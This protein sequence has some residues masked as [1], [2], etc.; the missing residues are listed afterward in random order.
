[1]GIVKPDKGSQGRG[2]VLAREKRDV[3]EALLKERG[4]A[5]R[6]VVDPFLIDGCPNK[7]D[8]RVYVLLSKGGSAAHLFLDGLAR[9]CS[10][11]YAR[12]GRKN[13][14][15]SS[16]HLSNYSLNAKHR[17]FVRDADSTDGGQG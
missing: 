10:S 3:T 15:K 14:A 1:M 7:W 13:L 9:F 17:G 6:Y 2:I 8:A 5:Q 11:P 12:P 16:I 4:V